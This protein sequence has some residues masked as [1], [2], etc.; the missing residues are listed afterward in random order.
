MDN[1]THSLTGSALAAAGLRRVSPL[2]TATLIVAANA[3]DVDALIYLIRDEY[4]AL[5]FRR[6]WTHGPLAMV[7]LPFVVAGAVLAWDRGVRRRRAP[8]AERAR[9]LPILLL[10]FLG[11]LTHPALDWMNTYGI[12]LLAPVSLRWYYGDALFIVD[13][14][15]WLVLG[16]ATFLAW[17]PRGRALVGWLALALAASALVLAVPLVPAAAK[18]VWLAG[19]AAVGVVHRTAEAAAPVGV[20]EG[21]AGARQ[22]AVAVA[23][24]A[25]AGP[26]A[27]TAAA[28]W[29]LALGVAYVLLMV[30][31]GRGAARLVREAAR[32][33]GIGP[34][35]RVMVAPVPAN[36]FRGEVVVAT[37]TAYHLG[38]FDWLGDP[39]VR[40]GPDSIVRAPRGPVIDAAADADA[41]RNYL[42]WSR[43]PFFRVDTLPDGYRVRIGDARYL[44]PGGAGSLA[45]VTVRLDRELRP[46]DR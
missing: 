6:G 39:R 22:A 1:L 12:R 7:V 9:P 2:G 13:P 10:A 19:L 40:L 36:P 32:D 28:R 24:R 41:A 17:A 23:R 27:R 5:S 25:G 34:V 14:W 8:A 21:G 18:A 45:G 4:F 46:V 29:A 3:P 37:P 31:S 20:W 11:V 15:L 30:G 35:E 44:D 43:F 42:A 38:A 16:A 26:D 33:R